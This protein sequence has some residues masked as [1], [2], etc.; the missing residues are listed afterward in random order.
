MFPL[1][2]PRADGSCSCGREKCVNAGKHPRNHNGVR[3]ATNDPLKIQKWWTAAPNANV[4]LH[5]GFGC[6]IDV[7]GRQGEHD[8]ARLEAQL[9]KLPATIEAETSKGRH[10]YYRTAAPMPSGI[11][12]LG[13]Q[14]IDLRASAA[15]VV[16]PPSLHR[17]GHVYKWRRGRSPFECGLAML[18]DAWGEQFLRCISPR[19]DS[20]IGNAPL[21]PHPQIGRDMSRSGVDARRTLDL[22][23]SAKTDSEIRMVLLQ[24]SSKACSEGDRYIRRTID[25]ARSFHSDLLRVAVRRAR[26]ER[27]PPSVFGQPEMIRIAIDAVTTRSK[28]IQFSIV[29][30]SPRYDSITIQRTY[31]AVLGHVITPGELAGMPHGSDARELLGVELEVARD[32]YSNVRWIRRAESEAAE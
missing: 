16:A 1:Y 6:V 17:S 22:V 11:H 24:T 13:S 27:L 8:L 29:V 14:Q 2:E 4:G 10:I 32:S 25:W 23:R 5:T 19:Q 21:K 7:D 26:L 15:Y 18:P 9:G 30:P 12:V 3:G 20:V 28:H 31:D